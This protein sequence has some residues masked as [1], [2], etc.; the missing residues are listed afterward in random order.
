MTERGDH[1]SDE[2]D[3]HAATEAV[4]AD[5]SSTGPRS[6][7]LD[8]KPT[9]GRFRILE[10][11]GSGGMG[12]V[13]RAHDSILDRP[14][15]LKI[16][17]SALGS[18][19][20][21]QR[22]R[23][24]VREARAAA[25]LTHPNAVTIFD[26]GEDGDDVFIAME[27]LEGEDLRAKLEKG[28]ASLEQKLRW[29]RDAARALA[30]AHER[31]LV[32]RDVKPENM[33]V[34]KDGTLKLLDFGIAKRE[35]T[36][37]DGVE[38]V[39][40]PA[41]SI[42]P[43]SLRTAV[44][45][46]L[47]TPRYMAPEQHAGEATDPRTDQYAWGLVA[48]EL[49]TGNLAI[50][51]LPTRTND[52]SGADTGLPEARFA[53][54]RT[55]VPEL[56]EEIARVI[57]RA[58]E[59]KKE[60]RFSS[61]DELLDAFESNQ[62]AEAARTGATREV[63]APRPDEETTRRAARARPVDA[64]RG[65]SLAILL[66]VATMAA[67]GASIAIVR[68]RQ[69]ALPPPLPALPACRVLDERTVTF[70]AEGTF[71]FDA[72]GMIVDAHGNGN[73]IV[74]E[75]EVPGGAA[76]RV[77]PPRQF[78]LNPLLYASVQPFGLRLGGSPYTAVMAITHPSSESGAAALF[79][80]FGGDGGGAMHR[81]YGPISG[82][83]V[84]RFRKELVI[85]TTIAESSN[86]LHGLV[87]AVEAYFPMRVSHPPIQLVKTPA[88]GPSVAA[89]DDR[90]AI[91]FNAK[92]HIQ[93]LL[94][95]EEGGQRGDVHEVAATTA[96]PM[97]TFHGKTVNVLWLEAEG[98]RTRLVARSLVVGETSFRPRRVVVDEPL[99]RFTVSTTSDGRPLVVWVTS[100][101]G[102]AT[103]RLAPLLEDGT[104][105]HPLDVAHPSDVKRVIGTPDRQEPSALAWRDQGNELHVSRMECPPPR[106]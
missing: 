67:I 53:E 76:Q 52:G 45:R 34:C 49:L 30:A 65:R 55:K 75:R 42:G 69:R 91:A 54:L 32:H 24:V 100:K 77:Q 82:V 16:V 21:T 84:E 72:D 51:S 70:P 5:G 88:Q 29:L 102:D 62:V 40:A 44:G 37:V 98:G 20:D 2:I 48:Y 31:G 89:G 38:A 92:G 3:A 12:D 19:D 79:Y 50:D 18:E 103:I 59:P 87:P 104:L 7:R 46:R 27:L 78:V 9:L 95:D 33:F 105:G 43:S 64:P 41:E 15:A 63:D 80:L 1:S 86:R 85:V 57:Q 58:L 93:F 99:T 11:L 10:T 23:R 71:G 61:M 39:D 6:K 83:T 4:S 97:V 66:V 25:A 47:G 81:L 60:E 17:R 106:P 94:I 96:N 56:P 68:G 36:D 14:V 35:A 74:I 73:E 26:V 22:R 28:N 13:Y 90:I 8:P 101:G